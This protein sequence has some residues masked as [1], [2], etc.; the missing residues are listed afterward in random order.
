[1][2]K[3]T[4]LLRLIP[5]KPSKGGSKTAQSTFTPNTDIR[6]AHNMWVYQGRWQKTPGLRSIAP[7]A[8]G[9]GIVESFSIH[10]F[11][12]Y[13][14]TN[15]SL[16]ATA[17]VLTHDKGSTGTNYLNALHL[18][19]GLRSAPVR[20][21]TATPDDC[22]PAVYANIKNRCFITWSGTNSFIY[23]GTG[24]TYNG[25]LSY[26]IGVDGPTTAPTYVTFG[27]GTVVGSADSAERSV[28]VANLSNKVNGAW[29]DP[30]TSSPVFGGI[31]TTGVSIGGVTYPLISPG[32]T[33]STFTIGGTCTGTSGT[34]QLTINGFLF[35]TSPDWIGLR[36]D[37]QS[38]TESHIIKSYAPS[39]ADTIVTLADDLTGNHATDTYAV[40]GTQLT[41]ASAYQGGTV[42]QTATVT[43]FNGALTWPGIGPQYAYAY[44]DPDTGHVSNVSPVLQV[45]EQDQL[46][47][48]IQ[49]QTIQPS[50]TE[51]QDRFTKIIIFRTQVAGGSVLYPLGTFGY[52]ATFLTLDNTGASTMTFIDTYP[53]DRLLQNGGLVAPLVNNAKPPP[54]T[55]Q[56]FFDQRVW[57]NPVGDPTAII[58]SGD[59][60]QVPF[61]VAE[62]SFPPLNQL[63]VPSDDGRVRGMKLVGNIGE[64]TT[65]RYSYGIVG[66][67]DSASYRLVRLGPQTFGVSDYQMDELPGD[68][69]DNS[70]VLA[71]LSRDSREFLLAPSYGNVPINDP[72]SDIFSGDIT[73]PALYYASRVHYYPATNV[74]L[75]INSLPNINMIFNFD[76]KTWC[77]AEATFFSS[78]AVRPEGLAT[79]Y[80]GTN[81]IDLY[82]VRAS[83]VYSWMDATFSSGPPTAYLETAPIDFSDGMK[84]R[85]R[86]PFV[87]VY[88]DAPT[89]TVTITVDEATVGIDIPAV[90]EQDPLYSLYA[91]TATPIDDPGAK[92]LVAFTL[93]PLSD[94]TTIATDGFRHQVRAALPADFARYSIYAIDIGYQFV[95]DEGSL[96]P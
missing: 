68:I 53:D 90:V 33:N 67:P 63:R 37:I 13:S 26:D 51:D 64:I 32:G 28:S 22:T 50:R 95:D 2:F 9:Q 41:L 47:Q 4:R 76:Q 86:I 62:E 70:A 74:R 8:G 19:S 77:S 79:I 27:S 30:L 40:N 71:Y 45:T 16:A 83:E 57:L 44:Y 89:C 14:L 48:S 54:A 25:E 36:I 29:N 6:V 39:G 5:D 58:F 65:D 59:F 78:A 60:Y 7:T 20:S 96:E 92:E 3:N 88:T 23:D 12:K 81:P 69:G 34:D 66:G 43:Y 82:I 38:P 15:A 46:G 85:S 1:M 56:M 61:G 42:F 72:V 35:P 52:P 94:G 93:K 84:R 49:L 18:D 31:S 55:H 73:T 11:L 10:S 75:L 91:A 21:T 80:G 24:T 87:R 17:V